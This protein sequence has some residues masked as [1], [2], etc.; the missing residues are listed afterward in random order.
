MKFGN[1]N[2]ERVGKEKGGKEVLFFFLRGCIRYV[3]SENYINMKSG[4][5]N[6]MFVNNFFFF[7]DECIVFL[8]CEKNI[9]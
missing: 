5:I 6:F 7:Y 9:G 8:F 4:N 2:N 3:K 1:E